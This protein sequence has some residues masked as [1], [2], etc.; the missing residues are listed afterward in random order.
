MTHGL[1]RAGFTKVYGY[2]ET[3]TL[4]ALDRLAVP[5]RF[6][7]VSQALEEWARSK[8]GSGSEPRSLE[9]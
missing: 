2:A 5:N 4:E 9:G 7:A 3:K 6:Q 1:P 8:L